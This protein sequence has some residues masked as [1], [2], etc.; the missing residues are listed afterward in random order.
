MPMTKSRSFYKFNRSF[1][2]AYR[3]IG[4]G[5]I[6]A[7]RLTRILNVDKPVTKKSWLHY[8]TTLRDVAEGVAKG[9]IKKAVIGAK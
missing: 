7:L 8:M 4:K 9:S 5:Y 6:A 2:L 1:I 3:L